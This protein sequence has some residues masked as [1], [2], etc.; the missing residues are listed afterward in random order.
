MNDGLT[1]T[2][3]YRMRHREEINA[4]RR[5]RRERRPRYRGGKGRW[6]LEKF[7]IPEPMSGCWLF[8]GK[9]HRE[10]YGRLNRGGKQHLAHRVFYEAF[11]GPIPDGYELDHLC[12]NKS[13]VNPRHL[14]AVPHQE[15]MQ[16]VDWSKR[17]RAA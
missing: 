10:G 9:R 16:R 17:R 14:E 13:C 12:K 7:Y 6:P 4:R 5:A 11:V 1:N 2:Q 8:T 15:N 3:R